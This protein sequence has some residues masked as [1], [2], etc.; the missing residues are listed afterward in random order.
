M[1]RLDRR[2]FLKACC[3]GAAASVAMWPWLKAAA[4]ASGSSDEFFILIHA[5]GGWDITLWSDP[6]NERRGLVEP[7]STDNTATDGIKH[8]TNAPLDADTNTFEL[9]R[10]PNS[11]LV[12][13]PTIGDL[14]SH[15]DRL[16]IINGL[17]M[18]TVSHPDG[19]AYSATGRHLAGGHAVASS[20]DTMLAN[21]LGTG[22]LFPSVSVQY[23]SS[24]VGN[25]DRRA[26]PLRVST[27]GT[28]AKSLTR[29]TS[30]EIAAERD[31]VTVMLSQEAQELADPVSY[32]HLTLPTIYSV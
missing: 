10:P 12:L 13:G 19:T 29:S 5:S 27:I 16:C 4:D 26:V 11:N 23:P 28:L 18:N 17:A 14:L 1:N 9:V 7:A 2:S 30:Y 20:V 22:Q 21:E 32:T 3:G 31:A 8:W 24:F 25:L 6:R 15:V